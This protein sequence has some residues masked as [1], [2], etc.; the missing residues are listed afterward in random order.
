MAPNNGGHCFRL[1]ATTDNKAIAKEQQQKHEYEQ[2]Q[3]Q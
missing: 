1:W 3:Q 2:Q